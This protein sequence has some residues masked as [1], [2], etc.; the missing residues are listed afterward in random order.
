MRP[1]PDIEQVAQPVSAAICRYILLLQI[2]QDVNEPEAGD[3][4]FRLIAE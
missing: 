2:V 4:I 1:D 3:C